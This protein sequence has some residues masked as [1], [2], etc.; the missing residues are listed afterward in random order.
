MAAAAGRTSITST[1]FYLQIFENSIKSRSL[2][3]AKA[4]H[5]HFLKNNYEFSPIVLD[6][7]TRV[8]I[9]FHKLQLAHRVF[10]Q[11]PY[12]ERK[13][14]V[15]LWNQLI[16]AYAWEGPFDH[17]IDL[18][19]E[20]IQ[21]GVTPNKYTYPFALKACSAIQDVELGKLIHDHVKTEFLDNDVYICTALV[22]FYAKCGLLDEARKVFD[23]MPNR[24]LVAWNAM[25]AGSSLHGMYHKTMRLIK[26]M[27]EVGLSPNSSTIVAILPAIGE[28]TDLMQGKT[29]HGFCIR[30]NFH[31]NVVVGTGLLD[32]YAKCEHLNYTRRVFNTITIKNE[33]TW[34]AII[35]AY[36]TKDSSMEALKLFNLAMVKNRA[37]ISPVTL[38]T[39]LRA[40]A[41]LTNINTGKCIHSYSIKSGFISHLIIN[42]TLLSLYSKCGIIK[43][44]MRV[45]NEMEFKDTVSFNS[46]I[47]GCVQN[48]NAEIA[49]NMFQKMKLLGFKPDVETM[50]GFFPACSHLGALKHGACG[51]SYAVTHE[52]IKSIKGKK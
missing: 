5:Q 20:M 6:K 39:I 46:I 24:D 37:N 32:M 2:A 41:N 8:Y 49:F 13:N 17:A 36:V 18:Y 7:L 50:I 42:N 12:P 47:S 22:D 28:A 35:S 52:F 25:I 19:I 34:S 27:Q 4:I 40:C 23:K 31:N 38:S 3:N 9:S 1:T 16:R 33:V 26:E 48:G 29:V 45:F 14:N 30:R 11:I 10:D 21:S 15:L 43:D 44:T 51:H